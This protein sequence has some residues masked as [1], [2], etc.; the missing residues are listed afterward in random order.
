MKKSKYSEEQIATALRLVEAGTPVAEVTRKLGICEATY[1][2][3]WTSIRK[4]LPNGCKRDVR[5]H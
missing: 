5:F 4:R 3:T 2:N 1:Y